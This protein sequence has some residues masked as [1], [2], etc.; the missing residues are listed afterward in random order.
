MP[1]SSLSAYMSLGI[2]SSTFGQMNLF[3][4]QSHVSNTTWHL[5]IFHGGKKQDKESTGP[6]LMVHAS[7]SSSSSHSLPLATLPPLTYHPCLEWL[8]LP[9]TQQNRKLKKQPRFFAPHFYIQL[10]GRHFK[11]YI[12]NILDYDLF[13]QPPPMPI[14]GPFCFQR[15]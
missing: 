1:S 9:S 2:S 15:G 5:Q 7:S 13:L 14:S 3:P 6:L 11:S 4:A 12:R 8:H 10:V